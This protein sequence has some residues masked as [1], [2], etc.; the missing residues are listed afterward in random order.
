[1]EKTYNR[2]QTE[3]VEA[4]DCFLF[5]P[6]CPRCWEA[7]VALSAGFEVVRWSSRAREER[8]EARRQ[9]DLPFRVIEGGRKDDEGPYSGHSNPRWYFRD[10]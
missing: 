3:Y 9:G 4:C 2:R 10:Y 7:G 8:E 6:E 5:S 1:M